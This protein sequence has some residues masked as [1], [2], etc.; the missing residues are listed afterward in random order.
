MAPINP[1]FSTNI[2]GITAIQP[3]QIQ[4]HNGRKQNINA[5][6]VMSSR[7]KRIWK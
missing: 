4:I 6:T 3:I 1:V 2:T 5:I 7:N